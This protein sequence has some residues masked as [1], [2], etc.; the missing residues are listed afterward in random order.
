MTNK[1]LA[2]VLAGAMML[3]AGCW[4]GNANNG[5]RTDGEQS[6][7]NGYIPWWK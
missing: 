4:T 6:V 1:I 3:F 7:F 2:M 5:E